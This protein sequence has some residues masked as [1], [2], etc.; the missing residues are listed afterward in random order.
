MRSRTATCQPLVEEL[1]PAPDPCDAA[2]RLADLPRL[3]WL[4]SA[5]PD[6]V[7]GRFSILTA[8]PFV[9][10]VARRGR[11]RLEWRDGGAEERDGDP[12]AVLAEL[13]ARYSV[14]RLP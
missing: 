7:L 5:R 11:I 14:D 13:L 12:F 2:R 1:R 9:W 4:D 3:L 10:M 6:G 8:D